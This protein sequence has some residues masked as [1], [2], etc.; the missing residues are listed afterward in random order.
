MLAM[1]DMLQKIQGLRC[2]LTSANT[3][4]GGNGLKLPRAVVAAGLIGVL[5]QK[6][7]TMT[8]LISTCWASESEVG[9]FQIFQIQEDMILFSL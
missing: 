9:F 1:A 3:V 6:V 5:L 8:C 4:P 7:N 2:S